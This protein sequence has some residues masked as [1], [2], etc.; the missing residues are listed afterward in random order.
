M[1]TRWTALGS[2]VR[3]WCSPTE[4]FVHWFRLPRADATIHDRGLVLVQIDG[5]PRAQLQRAL[6]RGRMPFLRSLLQREHYVLHDFYSGLPSSTPSV[7]GE[8]FY[9]PRCAVPAF[10]FRDH[11]TGE[12][13]R[14]FARD[15]A[16]DV[17][18]RL[19]Q[20]E[21]GVLAGGSAYCDI[22]GGGARETHFCASSLGWDDLMKSVRP[23]KLATLLLWHGW[24]IMRMIA[25]MVVELF[26][27]LVGF[28][29][30][31]LNGREYWQELMMIPARVVV[32]ILMRELAI[33]GATLDVTRGVPV[34]HLNLLG[35]DEQAHR[36]GPQSAFAH[37][38]LKGID[39]AIGRLWRAAHQSAKR[40]Y[41]VWVYSD[42]GQ[43][44]TTPY[45]YLCGK[46]I[47]DVANE[48]VREI[49]G[50]GDVA[51]IVHEWS[52]RDDATSNRARWLGSGWIVGKLFGEN[53]G[54]SRTRWEGV[55]VAALGPLGLVYTNRD[56]TVEKRL[57]IARRFVDRGVP[58][59]FVAFG[60]TV[61]GVT[62]EGQFDLR[63]EPERVFGADHPFLGDIA[64]D[65]LLLCQHPDAGDVV[66]S[67]WVRNGKS[68]SFVLQ[69]GA[70]AGPGHQETGAF[71]LLPND[72]SVLTGGKAY[73]R[74]ND[75][76]RAIKRF[77]DS[78]SPARASRPGTRSVARLR[79]MT[80]N[81]HACI[82]MD[83]QLSPHRIAR[84]IAQSHAEI[85]A[86]QE[87]DLC[88]A[89]SGY[90]DQALEIA[91]FLEMECQFHPAWQLEEE[92]YGDAILSRLPM[93]VVRKGPLGSAN[94]K[95]EPRGAMWVEVE[96]PGD[97][98][99][100]V[101]NTHLSIYPGE[102]NQQ[103]AELASAWVRP[104][105]ELGTTI[106]CGDLNATPNSQAYRHL[107]KI[108]ND[109]QSHAAVGTPSATFFNPRPLARIDHVFVSDDIVVETS[110]V[111]N[112]RLA[113]VASDHL[114]LVADLYVPHRAE[115]SLGSTE[116]E[117]ACS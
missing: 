68:L 103:A 93:R 40:E 106:V 109:V 37:W 64:E 16:L 31:A 65:M 8:L 51:D 33:V 18:H 85:V 43:E 1:I 15:V 70:H 114:P 100:Q 59:A 20:H 110:E 23:W 35:Y 116:R 38:T 62:H 87:L 36:R 14:M 54:E 47:D 58:I 9:G 74:P 69:N 56:P 107:N 63:R 73:L 86:L 112:S 83:R 94:G 76:R 49:C 78:P 80:Y 42:H 115:S 52:M 57:A 34:V 6:D 84:V 2:R 30:R 71:A 101:I 4:W 99:V 88:R 77:L 108:T 46:R 7:Q 89:R 5:L 75:L 96:L 105:K 24:S 41:D 17:Q 98:R 50:R 26:L 28:V 12:L 22:Y 27:A 13:E 10:G 91:R 60:D 25:L 113:R 104:A 53:A 95:R 29:R 32:V 102:R 61:V 66:V 111:L 21:P 55:Q 117:E 92:R 3:R 90:R 82:G 72:T 44:S 81:V 97:Q 79:V 11:R 48:V 67:G 39:L 45:E 19:E